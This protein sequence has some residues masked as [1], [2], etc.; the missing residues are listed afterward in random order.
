MGML[1]VKEGSGGL[2]IVV[3]VEQVNH[4]ANNS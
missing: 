3:D 1:V 4:E 2:Q